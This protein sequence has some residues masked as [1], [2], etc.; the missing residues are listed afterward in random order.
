MASYG[1][2]TAAADVGVA[3]LHYG[4]DPVR[5]G[6]VASFNRPGGN[7]TGATF[8]GTALTSKRMG[9]L[10]E[11]LPQVSDVALLVNPKSVYVGRILKGEKPSDLPIVQPTKF[12]LVVN[13]KAAKQL[14]IDIPPTLLARADDVIE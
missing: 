12:E 9:L 3:Q 5:D 11:I 4:G 14:S 1:A 2:I 7:V 6:L 10:R 13:L 8:I